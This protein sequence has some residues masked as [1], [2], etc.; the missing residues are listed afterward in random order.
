MRTILVGDLHLTVQI[1]LPM[2]EEKLTEFN[3]EQLILL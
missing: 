2:V 1:I 3:C